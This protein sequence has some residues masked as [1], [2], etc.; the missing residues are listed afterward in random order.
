MKKPEKKYDDMCMYIRN[1]TPVSLLDVSSI[2]V[3]CVFFLCSLFRFQYL[4]FSIKQYIVKFHLCDLFILFSLSH[5]SVPC[6]QYCMDDIIESTR[7]ET[8]YSLSF[9]L[10]LFFRFSSL[11]HFHAIKPCKSHSISR[12]RTTVESTYVRSRALSFSL[13]LTRVSSFDCRVTPLSL[14][15]FPRDLSVLNFSSLIAQRIL[16]YSHVRDRR[17][18]FLSLYE[19]C[20][21][22]LCRKQPL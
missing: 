22:R 11:E 7:F 15:R 12:S 5:L 16:S 21:H 19:N 10:I 17:K 8:Q 2:R 6:F 13:F 1:F 18:T 4:T 20:R 14:A 3:Q 9:S